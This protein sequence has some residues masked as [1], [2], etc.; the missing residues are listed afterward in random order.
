MPIR[1]RDDAAEIEDQIARFFSAQPDE[2]PRI[3]RR[4][5]A[6]M[7]DFPDVDGAVSLASAPDSVQLPD[8]A[9][10]IAQIE[11]V[12]VLYVALSETTSDRINKRE[13]AAAVK[14]IS[15]QLGDDLLVLFTNKSASQLHFI[16]PQFG[17]SA[18][19]TLRRMVVERDLPRRTAVQQ[20]SNVY[21]NHQDLGNIRDALDKAF[22]VEPVTKDFFKQYKALFERAESLIADRTDFADPEDCK[23]FVQTLFNRLMFVYFLS[24]KGWLK[25]ERN[26]DW[27]TDYLN[28]LWDAYDAHPEHDNF[29]EDRLTFLFF[30][31]LNNPDSRDLRGGV[32]FLIG[33]V[34]FL[35]GGL[36]EEDDLDKRAK[37][38]EIEVPDDA[39][40]PLMT[41]LFDRFN[42]T[43][44]ESTPFDIEVAV[45][46]EM[47]GKVF[48]EL[49]TERHDSG[50][51]YTPRPV[52]S[53]MC[54]EA[55]KGYLE[56]HLPVPDSLGDP[57]ASD[58]TQAPSGSPRE[59]GTE[60]PD[61]IAAFV[62]DYDASGL[63]LADARAISQALDEVTVVDPACGSGAYLVGMMQELVELQTALYS[64][65]LKH[66]A[67]S[68]YQLKLHIIERN[69]YG[70]D[71]D[72]FA[73]NIAMLRLWLSLAIEYE[74]DE[75]E[76]LPN[77]DFKILEGDSLLGPDPSETGQQGVL[78]YDGN[79][80]T[81]LRDLKQR[82]MT[83]SDPGRKVSLREAIERAES[84]IRDQL[85]HFAGADN[86][87]DW[88]IDFAE[89]IAE[90]G[91]DIA[92]ANPPYVRADANEEHQLARQLIQ[93]SGNFETLWEKWDL[94]IPFIERGIQVLKS[95]GH[96]MLI[97]SDAYCHAKYAQKSQNWLLEK[98][99]LVHLEFLGKLAIFS[100]SVR[101]MMLHVKKELA[102]NSKPIRREHY[103]EFG[104][105]T[106][107]NTAE[108]RHLSHRA[109]FPEDTYVELGAVETLTLRNICYISKGMAVHANEK[110]A[111]GAFRLHDLISAEKSEVHSRRFVEG[112]YVGRWV[113]TDGRWLEWDTKR[114]P[115]LFSRP[116]F[117]ELYDAPEKLISADMAAGTAALQVA[118][119]TDQLLHNHSAWSFVPWH[120]LSGVRNRS[121]KKVARYRDEGLAKSKKLDRH[122]LEEQSKRFDVKFLLGVMN[123][124]LARDFLRANRRSNIHLYP[125]DWK[126]L[127]IPIVPHDQQT[128]L[129]SIV[130]RILAT[131]NPDLDADTSAMETEIDRLVY[132]LYG[133][134]E[135]EIT[136]VEARAGRIG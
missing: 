4:L 33:D 103:P 122:R 69:L 25:Y 23:Q 32:D 93:N 78:G 51:Y 16:H 76:P 56:S 31:G 26:S 94:F 21:W 95:R 65:Q 74:H 75:P 24:R 27:D 120:S 110:L 97:V 43:V 41:D 40:R 14:L 38:G 11:G 81:Q 135:E 119:D 50:A 113:F 37:A 124:T 5:F 112:K 52:V 36:F 64:D 7:L 8:T 45:D 88:R 66:D 15:E 48:E 115:A 131:R 108:Q 12:H 1:S 83:E 9:S 133:L 3:L 18:S 117:P 89:V 130:D 92:I 57:L 20:V 82:F 58:S 70:V 84:D 47:L 104:K 35:N 59:A 121:I 107:L 105:V 73:V 134:T 132:D 118:Y 114:A 55:L 29:Y 72:P 85:S 126:E 30:E 90:G 127:P 80:V 106:I 6:E 101:N 123:S 116:T 136:A 128:I 62:D 19:P 98:H 111:K 22:D 44:M 96:C 125:D 42:F 68:L 2:R 77:L 53:F 129:A 100:A 102:P 67:R 86:A 71:L 39:I 49:I 54:R 17:S 34:P 91:F 63:S 79:R 109:F 13:A 10:R 60:V 87:L 99:R 28:A 46:P 61:P